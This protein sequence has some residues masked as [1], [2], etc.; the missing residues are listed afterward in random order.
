MSI[1]LLE[2]AADGLGPLL[3]EVVFVGGATV[4]LWITDPGAPPAR[5]TKDVDVVVEVATRSA[6]HDFEAGCDTAA[7][8]RTGRRA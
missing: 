8:R 1:E 2:L 3:D 7:S 5:P 4:T 6:F